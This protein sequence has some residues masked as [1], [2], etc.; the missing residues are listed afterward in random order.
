MF[1][2]ASD[3]F[4][5]L[6]VKVTDQASTSADSV[7]RNVADASSKAEESDSWSPK[8]KKKVR[9]VAAKTLKCDICP[10]RTNK[11]GLLTIHKTYHRPQA[12][13]TYKCTHCPYYV[14]A[15]RLLHQH[16]RIH[17]DAVQSTPNG[18]VGSKDRTPPKSDAATKAEP[19][20]QFRCSICPYVGR[21]RNDIIYHRQFHRS[22][23]TAPYRCPSCP[24]WVGEKRTLAQ[25][26]KVHREVDRQPST[27]E[28][29]T[30]EQNGDSKESM[31]AG[32]EVEGGREN[33]QSVDA[34]STTSCVAHNGG[35]KASGSNP[36]VD[37]S[38]ADQ[39]RDTPDGRR[40]RVARTLWRCDRCPYVTAKR[41]QHQTHR[42][43][44]GSCQRHTC[45]LCDYS[46]GGLHLLMQHVRLHHG[47]PDIDPDS[48]K[49]ATEQPASNDPPPEDSQ[50]T[51]SSKQDRPLFRCDR[52]PYANSRRDHLLC[53]SRFHNS[54]G[55]LRCPQCD[56]SVSKVHLLT[57]HMRVHQL[58]D[59]HNSSK[60]GAH[61][62]K[63][64]FM[65]SLSLT[66]R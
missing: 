4:R 26:Q 5:C 27:T 52:C 42:Q 45:R 14:C 6:Q 15:P 11:L 19:A 60:T 37:G 7:S 48:A 17:L 18:D 39:Q 2:I 38:K 3:G 1:S 43:L 57:Q 30:G 21:S 56:Y 49:P 54:D 47:Q 25:H 66:T 34:R 62:T 36:V 28:G 24:F 29:V 8:K 58:I 16:V 53:H 10:Y 31:R 46:V 50:T 22:R 23:P 55:P 41:S 20:A 44:H 65:R 33:I 59:I 40:R 64:Q 13:N 32:D 51:S 35:N 9:P 61:A 63:D 12:K